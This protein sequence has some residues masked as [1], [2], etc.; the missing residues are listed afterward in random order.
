[1]ENFRILLLIFLVLC[2][3]FVSFTK[4]LL[5]SVMTFMSYSSIM[6]IIWVLF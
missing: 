1:M 3:L 4:N 2:A 5:A 6:A